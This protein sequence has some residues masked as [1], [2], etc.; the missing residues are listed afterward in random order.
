MEEP[1]WTKTSHSG[2]CLRSCAWLTFPKWVSSTH[3]SAESATSNTRNITS[4][5]LP[6]SIRE[7][8]TSVTCFPCKTMTVS[9]TCGLCIHSSYASGSSTKVFELHTWVAGRRS[10]LEQMTTYSKPR[11]GFLTVYLSLSDW[12]PWSACTTHAYCSPRRAGICGTASADAHDSCYLRPTKCC[13]S[14]DFPI[15]R[16]VK[17]SIWQLVARE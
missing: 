13:Q 14:G 1:R 10:H 4:C 15:S 5:Q 17:L 6:S 3:V 8:R 9:L 7:I 2:C 11:F 16:V 12:I